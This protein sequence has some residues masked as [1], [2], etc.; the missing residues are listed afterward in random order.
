MISYALWQRR[1]AGSPKVIG[2]PLTL[3]SRTYTVAGVMPRDFK[4]TYLSPGSG[5][6]T[7]VWTPL[8]FTA[9]QLEGQGGTGWNLRV[10]GHIKSGITFDHARSELA[11]IGAGFVDRFPKTY[12]GPGGEDGGWSTTLFPLEG[13]I[14]G[15]IR[16]PL[17]I[18]F[19]AVGFLMLIACANVANLMLAR[20]SGRRREMAIRLSMGAARS[21]IVRQLLTES[22]LLALAGVGLGML[23]VWIGKR[24]LIG[25]GPSDI[26]RLSEI[27]IDL[28]VLAF[29]LAAG[30][31]ASVIFGLAPAIE[32]CKVDLLES[33]ETGA[34]KREDAMGSAALTDCV[35]SCPGA[36]PANRRWANT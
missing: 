3:E 4:P 36:G 11:V 7:E 23:F 5:A 19:A 18:L 8:I 28:R 14:V 20:G 1:F 10:I 29:A 32:A 21:R 12:R 6:E 13:E 17:L 24:V 2:T 35:R 31:V 22:M 30:L 25:L 16:Q 27:V 9:E 34:P 33:H 15:S 26:P